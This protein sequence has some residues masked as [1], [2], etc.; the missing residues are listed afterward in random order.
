MDLLLIARKIWRHKFVTVPVI[1]LT[2]AG[3]GYVVTVKQPLYEASSSYLLINPPAA[4]TA[5]D[6]ARNPALANVRADNPYTRFADQSVII[7]VLSRTINSDSA[8]RRLLRAGADPRYVVESASRFGTTSP[9]VQI[10][11]TGP[12]PH[13]AMRTAEVVGHAVV[14]ELDRMQQVQ[15]V[16]PRYRITT[17]QVEFPDGPRL[18]PS[19][20]LRMLVAVLVLGA[21]LLFIVVSVTDALETLRRERWAARAEREWTADEF[22]LLDPQPDLG[23]A[24]RTNGHVERVREPDADTWVPPAR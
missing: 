3:A 20:Q 24:L 22:A 5:D 10:T 9:I 6:I 17:L 11:G 21:I 1:L 13:A 12:T 23:T 14:G 2:I 18:Q 4:P 19:G 8:R 15:K 16:D 7:D